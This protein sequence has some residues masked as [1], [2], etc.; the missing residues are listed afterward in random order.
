ML[1]PDR[2]PSNQLRE[3]WVMP[4]FSIIIPAYGNAKYLSVCLDSLKD[5][6]FGDWEAIVVVDGSPDESL[7]IAEWYSGRDGRFVVVGKEV[8]EGTHLARCSGVDAAC[9][10]YGVFLDADDCLLPDALERL[11]EAIRLCDDFDILRFGSRVVGEGVSSDVVESLRKMSNVSLPDLS[12]AEILESSFLPEGKRAQD[13]RVLQRVYS[14]TT[15]KL[16]FDVMSKQRF[17]RG[18]DAYECY[19]IASVASRQIT[20]ADIDGYEYHIGRGVTNDRAMSLDSFCKL[21]KGYS[22]ILQAASDI[23]SS[24]VLRRCSHCL[25][26]FYSLLLTYLMEDWHTRVLDDVK[27]PAAE[28]VVSLFGV[29]NVVEEIYRIV[30]D[31]AYSVWDK[32][33]VICGTESFLD[34]LKIANLLKKDAS[35]VDGRLKYEERAKSHIRDLLNRTKTF[36]RSPF[37]RYRAWRISRKLAREL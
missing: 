28:C 15:L 31:E 2:G 14:M 30:R 18:Q 25:E 8:N 16:A 36:A 13:W 22:E 23:P 27:L 12:G 24:C 3:S 7:C 34:W 17:G 19:V 5:Q 37:A 35:M 1:V 4:F 6:S 29:R 11:E 32:G 21:A 33:G 20:R 26:G 9:G 10:E